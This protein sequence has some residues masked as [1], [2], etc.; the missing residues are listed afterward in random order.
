MQSAIKDERP[1]QRGRKRLSYADAVFSAVFKV[2]S[3]MSGR[4]FMTDMREAHEAGHTSRAIHYNSIFDI[5]EAPETGA[6]LQS[7]IVAAPTP[8][9]PRK[10]F[11][12]RFVGIQRLQV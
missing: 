8:Q 12:G 6:I 10:Q 4:R 3:G 5:L 11:R 7:L 9:S 2:Y 1:P